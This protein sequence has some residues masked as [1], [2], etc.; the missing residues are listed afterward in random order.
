MILRFLKAAVAGIFIVMAGGASA[1]HTYVSK[2]DSARV[3]SISGTISSV[4]YQNPH[5]HFTLETAKGSWVVETESISVARASGLTEEVLKA[6]A[7]ATASGW[8]ARAG[9]GALG[10]KS[11]SIGGRSYVLRRTA[12]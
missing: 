5:I 10:L 2:Y 8:P 11:V 3:I 9:G 7:K 6:G 4:S 1:H 12:R